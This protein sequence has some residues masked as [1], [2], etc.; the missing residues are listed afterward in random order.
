MKLELYYV[1]QKF[2]ENGNVME[3]PRY[4]SGPF[5]SWDRAD[6]EIASHWLHNNCYAIVKQIIDVEEV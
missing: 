6:A 4:Q 1:I 3:E 5:V 2:W